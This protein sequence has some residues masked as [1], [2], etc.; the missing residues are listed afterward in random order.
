[1]KRQSE[2]LISKVD[3][4]EITRLHFE[5]TYASGKAYLEEARRLADT[6]DLLSSLDLGRDGLKI[7]NFEAH[8]GMSLR[9]QLREHERCLQLRIDEIVQ[10]LLE[11]V[12]A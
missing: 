4:F 2:L 10:H 3:A 5:T 8:Y 11:G 9:P 7:T 6:G 12:S 1:M